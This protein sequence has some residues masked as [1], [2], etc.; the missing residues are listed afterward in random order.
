MRD[1]RWHIGCS[2]ALFVENALPHESDE[3]NQ[4]PIACRSCAAYSRAIETLIAAQVPFLVG[5]GFAVEVFV[6]APRARIKDLDLFLRPIDVGTALQALTHNGF[7]TRLHEP[8]W[9]AKAYDGDDFIDL[10][11]ATRNGLLEVDDQSFVDAPR[12]RVLGHEVA[13]QPVE[14]VI[15][16]KIFVMARDRFD[17]SDISHLILR[18]GERIDWRRLIERLAP[19]IEMLHVYLLLFQYIYPGQR[20]HVPSWVYDEVDARARNARERA[21]PDKSSRGLALD[22][23]AFAIDIERWGFFDGMR[24]EQVRSGPVPG[25]EIPPTDDPRRDAA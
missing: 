19:H 1:E 2:L 3:V 5:G 20:A 17:V 24:A 18:F 16:T 22:P 12:Q 4:A 14:E 11:Y 13:V 9:I 23:V 6:D 15:A 8:H 21:S 25:A 7:V 10:I